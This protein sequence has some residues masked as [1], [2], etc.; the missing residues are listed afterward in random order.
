MSGKWRRETFLALHHT[1]EEVEEIP[2]D[3]SE[4]I[5]EHISQVLHVL[6]TGSRDV[7]AQQRTALSDLARPLTTVDTLVHKALKLNHKCKTEAILVGSLRTLCYSPGA[8][9]DS[10]TMVVDGT[11]DTQSDDDMQDEPEVQDKQRIILSTFGLGLAVTQ[12]GEFGRELI[13]VNR[14]IVT[15]E[16]SRDVAN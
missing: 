14:A 8:S 3:I 16:T 9:F 4:S 1:L 12:V 5:K 13:L 7:S 11:K 2:E 15:D 6:F 10:H